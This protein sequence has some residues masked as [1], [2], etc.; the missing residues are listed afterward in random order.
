MSVSDLWAFLML[1]PQEA[2]GKPKLLGSRVS[3][4]YCAP[5]TFKFFAPK[6]KIQK[7]ALGE[8][9]NSIRQLSFLKQQLCILDGWC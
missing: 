8:F 7:I 6:K 4:G 9:R 2:S 1:A 3:M 5:L